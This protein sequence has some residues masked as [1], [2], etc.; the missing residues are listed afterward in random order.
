ME[1]KTFKSRLFRRTIKPDNLDYWMYLYAEALYRLKQLEDLN[2]PCSSC[3]GDKIKTKH[4]LEKLEN[5]EHIPQNKRPTNF[6]GIGDC[7][8]RLPPRA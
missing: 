4:L 1:R 8:R 2:C 5:D 3:F 6:T 7:G